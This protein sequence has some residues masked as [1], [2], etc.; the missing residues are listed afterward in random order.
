VKSNVHAYPDGPEAPRLWGSLLTL[1]DWQRAEPRALLS[2]RAFNEH[3]TAAGFA[4]GADRLAA[5]DAGILALFGAGKSAPLTLRYLKAVR[6][7]IR[8]IRLA[9]RAPGRVQALAAQ[10]AHWPEFAD[11]RICCAASP[12]AAVAGA[13]LV[14]TV[15]TADQ[16]VFPG[17]AVKPG[18]CIIL[19]GANRPEAR[20]ADDALMRRADLYVDARQGATDKAGDIRLALESGALIAERIRAEIGAVPAGG[21]PLSEGSDLRVFKSM[22]LAIQDVILA[23]YL[24]DRAEAAGRGLMVDLAGGGS[25]PC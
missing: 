12:E 1:W 18:A 17:A 24:V 25:P 4:V 6:P 2:A 19:G 20:E 3:R 11:T 21:L 10:A 14:A 22:G 8:E 15:T 5:P 16:P 23:E 7:S 9:G 13:D